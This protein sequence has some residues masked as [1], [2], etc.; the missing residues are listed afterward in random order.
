MVWFSHGISSPYL[1]TNIIYNDNVFDK[2]IEGK[3]NGKKWNEYGLTDSNLSENQRNINW[4]N[5]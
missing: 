4:I 3:S 2:I 5:N 1:L